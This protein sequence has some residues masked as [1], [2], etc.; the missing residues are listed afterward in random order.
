VD[1]S[2]AVTTL[3]FLFLGSPGRLPCG[4]GSAADPANV[5]LLDWQPDGTIDLSDGVALLSFL[6]LGGQPHALVPQ[7][8]AK[9]CV[10]IA[11]CPDSCR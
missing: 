1:I 6:F 9:G 3:G 2:D 11:G 5:G 8:D 4:D 10:P 7:A